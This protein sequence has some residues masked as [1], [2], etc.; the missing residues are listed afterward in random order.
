MSILYGFVSLIA[1]IIG[2][3]SGIG[4]GIIIKPVLDSTGVLQ[5][6]TISFLSGCTVLAMTTTNLIVNIR[7]KVHYEKQM[8]VLLMMGSALGGFLGSELLRVI[9]SM[10]VENGQL[11]FIQNGLLLMV[12]GSVAVFM[13]HKCRIQTK[14]VQSPM[15]ILLIGMSLGLLSSFLGIGGGPMNL[16]VLM[17]FF[18]MGQ[19]ESARTSLMMIFF[20]QWVSLSTT[21]LTNQVPVVEWY[22]VLLM[23]VGGISGGLIGTHIALKIG[24]RLRTRLFQYVLFF[25]IVVNVYNL[26]QFGV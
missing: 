22:Y 15:L 1:S 26:V 11:G 14:T 3:I 6:A 10:G 8:V 16:A 19:M 23:C 24:E 20:A 25:V 12:N 21:I 5:V 13:L 18:S 7:N 2:A 9:K 17:Y 4:G